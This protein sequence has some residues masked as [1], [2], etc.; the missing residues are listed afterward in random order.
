MAWRRSCRTDGPTGTSGNC[1]AVP[2]G[3]ACG[4]VLGTDSP[5]PGV[6]AFPHSR[7]FTGT[8]RHRCGG[9]RESGE[10]ALENSG[11]ARWTARYG[12]VD[13]DD[14]RHAPA[15]GVAFAK[16]A[17]GAATVANGD[18]ELGIGRGL[19]RPAQR[20]LHVFRHR[21][22]DQQQIGV[23]GA[24]DKPNTQPFKVVEGI[25]DGVD[26]ELA[27]VA[28]ACVDVTDTQRAAK[29][30][31]NVV[32]QAVAKAQGFIRLWRRLGDNADR[33]NLTECFQHGGALQV[34]ATVGKV[35]GLVD[36]REVRDDVADD[37]MLEHGPVLPGGIVR[38]TAADCPGG[39]GFERDPH[40]P[41]PAFD[42]PGTDRPFSRYLQRCTVRSCC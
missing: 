30:G 36:E 2:G 14:V 8:C 12:Y 16:D 23:A 42:Q 26:L 5:S 31:T 20:H 13:R 1:P 28:R 34:M 15:T 32:L 24:C 17:A 33:Y 4:V 18:Y 40:W 7:L 35:E 10:N 41:A 22:R 21:A 11:W 27:A 39:A 3:A 6:A 25:V 37:G 29:H 19:I 9:A 38:V